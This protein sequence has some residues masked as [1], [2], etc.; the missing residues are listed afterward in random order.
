M[1]FVHTKLALEEME[2]GQILEVTL[3][4]PAAFTSVPRSVKIQHLGAVI[5][6]AMDGDAKTFWIKRL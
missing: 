3:D 4:D 1:T 6:E 5:H 2:P